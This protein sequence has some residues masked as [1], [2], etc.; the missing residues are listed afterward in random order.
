MYRLKPAGLALAIL[1]LI[2]VIS[3][4]VF[5]LTREHVIDE[6]P[7][8]ITI[9]PTSLPD[10]KPTPELTPQTFSATPSPSDEEDVRESIEPAGSAQDYST[11]GW[12]QDAHDP[13]RTGYTQEEPA[14][15]WRLLWTWNGPDSKG[16][17]GDHFYDAPP[18]A[19]SVT[20]DCCVFVPAG[21]QGLFA[22]N[23][24]DGQPVWNFDGAA[25]N[26]AP[27]YDPETG[28]LYAGSDNGFL[29]KID[30]LSGDIAGEYH[31][32]S[33]LDKALLATGRHV[34]AVSMDGGLHKVDMETMTA[35][36]VYSAAAS[37]STPAAYSSRYGLIIYGTSDL[38]VHAVGVADGSTRWVTKP[39]P[40]D[41]NDGPYTYAG[42]WPVVADNSGVVFVRI[43]LGMS[44]LW[45]GPNEGN[46]YPEDNQATRQYLEDKPH[47]QN[48]YAL[49]LDDGQPAF[50][51]AVGY[52]GV[53]TTEASSRELAGGPVP[54]VRRFA[55]GSEVAY[56]FFRSAQGDP[57]DG[58]WDSH[59]GE[60]VLD[61]KTIP[62]L[63]AGDLRFISFE[64]SYTH[65]TDEQ[66]PLSM[67]GDSLFHAHWGASESVRIT[68]RSP[69]LGLS[70]SNPIQTQPHP[71]VIRRMQ[72]CPSYDPVA[73]WTS[74]D[75]TLY[76]DGRTWKGPGWWVY[77]DVLDPPTPPTRAY[78]EGHLPRYTYVSDGLVIVS[79]NGGE[80]MVFAHSGNPE[81][82]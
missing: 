79:G 72:A 25:F 36:W 68:D 69:E 9:S 45:S 11:L 50:V 53:E 70:F 34:Y 77:W 54:V 41:A 81:S 31:G 48:L 22:L 32:G 64:N 47:L 20:G 44:A 27:A 15:P 61:N 76:S 39:S 60:M 14:Q 80:L 52:G 59:I 66:C 78:S 30:P 13:A 49:R 56:S 19:R 28:Y 7:V 71:V 24:H 17:T 3:G 55:D 42:Y 38:Q 46:I 73:H 40:L 2:V 51:P 57:P 26:A 12:H 82:N 5:V 6:E 21:E 8:P 33:V 37:A 65:I 10:P 58:R 35:A 67:A 74:C 1:T 63:Q 23:K 43:N 29:Y 75:L 18:E 62:G 4:L 16:G